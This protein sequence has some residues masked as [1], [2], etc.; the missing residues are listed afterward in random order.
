MPAKSDYFK[1]TWNFYFARNLLRN[2]PYRMQDFLYMRPDEIAARIRKKLRQMRKL[3]QYRLNKRVGKT[4]KL[5]AQDLI[6]SAEEFPEHVQ[7]VI[8]LNYRALK[9][10]TP[11]PYTGDITLLRAIGGRLF[12]S[13]DPQMGWGKLTNG[14]IDVR[15][16]PGSHL[17]IFKEP[18]VRELAEQLRLSIEEAGHKY[19]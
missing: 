2:L 8:D 7:R 4:I 6:D 1:V 11:Q 16:I 9:Q 12:C 3:L 19:D 10:F 13:H 14:R 17:R 18:H 5:E 15:I